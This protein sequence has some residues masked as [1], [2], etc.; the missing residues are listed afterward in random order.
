MS[1]T[2]ITTQGGLQRRRIR[3]DGWTDKRRTLFLDALA[4]SCNV[5]LAAAAAGR[6]AHS[7]YKLRQRD[8]EFAG[9]WQ[10]ALRICYERLETAL[11]R[12]ALKLT[13]ADRADTDRD[14]DDG[15][16]SRAPSDASFA[17]MTVSQAM[18]LLAKHKASLAQQS[19]ARINLR[20]VPTS[21]EVDDMII[22]KIAVLKRQKERVT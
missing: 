8:A 21:A 22:A 2:E 20:R 7:A 4:D 1:D 9:H 12:R 14:P 19:G 6:S 18:E 3:K 5:T 13:G 11:L 16:S 10:A 15:R 17:D